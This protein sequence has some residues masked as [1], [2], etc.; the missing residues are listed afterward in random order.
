LTTAHAILF[1]LFLG[2]TFTAGICIVPDAREQSEPARVDLI[3][4]R[5]L[6]DNLEKR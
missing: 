1:I 5:V 6:A 4:L 2:S 3:K